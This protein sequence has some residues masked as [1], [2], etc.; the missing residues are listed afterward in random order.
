M[1]YYAIGDI[2]GQLDMLRRAHD[3]IDADR[4]V[5]GDQDAPVVHLG[6]FCDRGPDT[7][8]VIQTLIDGISERQPWV[9]LKGNHDRLFSGFLED[10]IWE[11]PYLKDQLA[12][13]DPRLGGSETLAS[14]G[15]EDAGNR[16]LADVHREA[17]VTVPPEHLQFLDDLPLYHETSELIFVHAGIRPGV[18]MEQQTEHDLIWI[19]DEFLEDDTDHGRLVVHG[20]T[21]LEQ[22]TH[23]GNRIDL[24]SGAAYFRP[25]TAAV[26]EG[27]TC[28]V[29]TDVGRVPLLPP[30]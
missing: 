22:A 18:R 11:D 6:D 26:I 16:P 5:C 17:S 14:Y 9:A 20:H 23:F 8:G 29:L 24:D 4:R 30:G 13:F 7:K 3:R 21:A 1:R 10:H 12:W 25:L 28:W 2:H 15:I 19:R 27:R